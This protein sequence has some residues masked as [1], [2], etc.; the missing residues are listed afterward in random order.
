MVRC[1]CCSFHKCRTSWGWIA[2]D[3]NCILLREIG[4]YRL[5]R[6]N[7]VLKPKAIH[8]KAN[9]QNSSKEHQSFIPLVDVFCCAFPSA[10]IFV[11]MPYKSWPIYLEIDQL[12]VSTRGNL[13]RDGSGFTQSF[14]HNLC[15]TTKPAIV[16]ASI[17]DCVT[18]VLGEIGHTNRKAGGT[19]S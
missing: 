15:T 8:S 4:S 17:S 6:F 1:L 9:V 3:S 7:H 10:T 13:D 2:I 12:I 5:N 11:S 16:N 18:A 14:L 19:P